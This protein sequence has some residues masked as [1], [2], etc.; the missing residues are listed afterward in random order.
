MHP[1]FTEMSIDRQT[2]CIRLRRAKGDRSVLRDVRN[3]M[4]EGLGAYVADVHV[5]TGVHV[6]E[7]IPADMVGVLV[8]DEIIAAVPAP[9]GTNGPVPRTQLQSKSHPGSQNR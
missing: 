7:Q 9:I 8:Y 6:I 2:R 5:D 3:S 4:L 1:Q